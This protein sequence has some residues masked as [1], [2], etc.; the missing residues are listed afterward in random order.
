MSF[1]NEYDKEM[2]KQDLEKRKIFSFKGTKGI[3]LYL[4]ALNIVFIVIIVVF[5]IILPPLIPYYLIIAGFLFFG[6][7]VLDLFFWIEISGRNIEIT[8]EGINWKGHSYSAYIKFIDI[9]DISYFPSPFLGL[10]TAKIFTNDN[11]RLKLRISFMTTPKNWVS[12]EMIRTIV[13]H[14]WRKANP[15]AKY[16]VE[17]VSSIPSVQPKTISLIKPSASTQ[18]AEEFQGYKCPNCLFIY[19]KTHKFCPKC[20]TKME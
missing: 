5:L 1:S 7:I 17:S 19:D 8:P 10:S 6:I 16:S 15:E 12:E 9:E 18:Q 20:G 4:C 14:Y 11:R 13:D 3:P 2:F